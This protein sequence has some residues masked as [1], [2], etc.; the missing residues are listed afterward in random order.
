MDFVH[1]IIVIILALELDSIEFDFVVYV[2]YCIADPICMHP[3]S[4]VEH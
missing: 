2:F 4:V 1:V 3:A